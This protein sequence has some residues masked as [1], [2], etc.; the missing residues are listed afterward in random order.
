[1]YIIRSIS[2]VRKM[3]KGLRKISPARNQAQDTRKRTSVRGSIS[4]INEL[5]ANSDD[6]RAARGCAVFVLVRHYPSKLN[7]H[8]Y[9]SAA[10]SSVILNRDR[11][12]CSGKQ[13]SP[14][15]RARENT[16]RIVP[17]IQV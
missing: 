10:S 17:K 12:S 6:E 9:S 3:M 7:T 14:R 8:S 1:M 4:I 5:L 15:A 11:Q 13:I 16:Y 2:D